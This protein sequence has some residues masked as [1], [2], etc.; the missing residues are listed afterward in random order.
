MRPGR[1]PGARLNWQRRPP[2][3]LPLHRQDEVRADRP[4]LSWQELCST[5]LGDQ[6]QRPD[7]GPNETVDTLLS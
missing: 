1:M 5:T 3:S 6:S 7:Y 2:P 4:G